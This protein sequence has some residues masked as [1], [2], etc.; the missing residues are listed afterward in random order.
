MHKRRG[1]AIS[2]AKQKKKAE[3]LAALPIVSEE[4]K[5]ATKKA[6]YQKQWTPERRAA[7]AETNNMRQGVT[8]EVELRRAETLRATHAKRKAEK[9]LAAADR[10]SA[11]LIRQQEQ[12]DAWI[13]QNC[14]RGQGFLQLRLE[15]FSDYANFTTEPMKQTQFYAALEQRGF[16][17]KK[18]SSRYYLGL[19]LAATS[20]TP[21]TEST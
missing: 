14:E 1:L 5:A 20:A 19:K 13:G 3:R 21:Y 16:I 8:R 11:M 9:N 4:E 15:L 6:N 18:T 7:Q 2:A 17:M 10:A 12:F